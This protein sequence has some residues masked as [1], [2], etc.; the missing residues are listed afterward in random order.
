MANYLVASRGEGHPRQE[1]LQQ[2][3]GAMLAAC[4]AA[5]NVPQDELGKWFESEQLNDPNH[6][7]PPLDRA[8]EELVGD[9]DWLFDRSPLQ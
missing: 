5:R 8:L 7:L 2:T 1:E 4:A 6:F 3:A 9:E